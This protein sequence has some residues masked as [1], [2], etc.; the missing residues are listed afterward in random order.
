MAGSESAAGGEDSVG[1]EDV[2]G[3]K[4]AEMKRRRR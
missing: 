1:G 3:G 2:I 4:T